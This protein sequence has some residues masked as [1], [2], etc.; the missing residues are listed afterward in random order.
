MLKLLFRR[1]AAALGLAGLAAGVSAAAEAPQTVRPALWEVSDADTT[2]YLFGT[3]HLLPEHYHWRTAQFDQVVKV[4]RELV[5]ETIVDDK[6]PA[7]LVAA[8]QKL[9]FSPA[10]PPI[11]ERVPPA[12]RPALD[13]AIAK[14]GL[15]AI[16]YDKME[17]WAAA[18]LLMGNQF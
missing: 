10:L 2:I 9:A 5:V 15:P 3:I 4:S 13:E 17:T 18:F 14:S 1:V 12:Q 16:A 6:N 8:M 11:A 7:Q